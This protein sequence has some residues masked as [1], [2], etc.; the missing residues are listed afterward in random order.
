MIIGAGKRGKEEVPRQVRGARPFFLAP[1]CGQEIDTETQRFRG[2]IHERRD[3]G[4][5]LEPSDV[6]LCLFSSVSLL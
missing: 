3:D 2:R 6:S 4:H 5:D 1:V